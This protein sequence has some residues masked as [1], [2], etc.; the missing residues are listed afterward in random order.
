[1]TADRCCWHEPGGR[2]GEPIAFPAAEEA[3]PFCARH[4]L[5]L[6]PWIRSRAAR[7]SNA[8]EWI[9]TGPRPGR[10]ARGAASRRLGVLRPPILADGRPPGP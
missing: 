8:E 4:L 2:C 5:K 9:A 6:E 3:P 1:M 7:S 10:L